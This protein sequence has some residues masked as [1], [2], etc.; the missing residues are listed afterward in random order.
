MDN[1][2]TV[3]TAGS[4]SLQP[5]PGEQVFLQDG[6]AFVTNLRLIFNGESR[7]YATSGVT[8]VGLTVKPQK[9]AGAILLGLIAVMC[10]AGQ[11]IVVG[12]VL[13]VIA[14]CFWA[15]GRPKYFLSLHTAGVCYNPLWS[16]DRQ[17][18]TRI[19]GAVNNAIIARG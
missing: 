7:V 6:N 17:Y 19:V 13:F 14:F 5:A 15:A 1:A 3:Q 16:R 11:A 4:A 12:A 2:I 18:V 9:W 10:L 8:S